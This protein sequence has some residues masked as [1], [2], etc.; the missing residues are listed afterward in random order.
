VLPVFDPR[1]H[2]TLKR[3]EI[4]DNKYDLKDLRG[5]VE[6]F[7]EEYYNRQRTRSALGYPSPEE[8]EQRANCKAVSFIF[9]ARSAYFHS[10]PLNHCGIDCTD[11]IYSRL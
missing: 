7:I 2:K 6:E 11:A 4:Y 8:F 1:P 9:I 5:N 3:E 10:N